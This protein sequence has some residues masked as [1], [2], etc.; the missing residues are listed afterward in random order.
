[1]NPLEFLGFRFQYTFWL[2]GV[3]HQD[4]WLPLGRP[5]IVFLPL[6]PATLHLAGS[7]RQCASSAKTVADCNETG[8]TAI[9]AFSDHIPASITRS[10]HLVQ[11]RRNQPPGLQSIAPVHL[12]CN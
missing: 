3:M 8:Q 5:G 12:P 11:L 1:M 6:R 4:G 9:I 2:L 7:V 10:D